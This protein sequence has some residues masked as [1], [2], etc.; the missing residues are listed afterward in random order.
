MAQLRYFRAERSRTD[1]VVVMLPDVS[2]TAELLPSA[3]EYKKLVEEVLPA[4]LQSK[5]GAIDA[6]PFVPSAELLK[7]VAPV[8]EEEAEQK[9][10]VVDAAPAETP[11][12]PAADSQTAVKEAPKESAGADASEL[13]V[14][15]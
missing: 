12:E 15:S 2:G 14:Q 8:K 1:T 4:Q 10:P 13:E 7:E 6:E 9:A 5:L 11:A 3:E